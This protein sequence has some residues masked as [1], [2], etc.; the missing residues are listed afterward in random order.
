MFWCRCFYLFFCEGGNIFAIALFLGLR[1]LSVDTFRWCSFSCSCWWSLG[2]QIILEFS[3]VNHLTTKVSIDL[4]SSS[5][6][7]GAG[8]FELASNLRHVV[9]FFP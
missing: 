6:Q 1:G 4:N 3:P 7:P 5:L 2:L 8:H 9:V